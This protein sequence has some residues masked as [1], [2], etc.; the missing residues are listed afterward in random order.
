MLI[1]AFD[2]ATDMCTVAL[3]KDEVL[4]KEI[5]LHAERTHMGKLIPLID[6]L[7]GETNFKIKNVDGI[8]VGLGPGSFTGMRIG[9]STARGL[10]Q[11]L[12]KPVVGVSTLDCLAYPFINS[13]SL[14]LTV[15]DAKRKEIYATLYEASEGKLN[16]LTNY[17]VMAPESLVEN[18]K[19]EKRG[20]IMVGDGLKVYGELFKQSLKGALFVEEAFWYPRAANL[21]VPGRLKF[22]FESGDFNE[23][24]PIYARLSQAEEIWLNKKGK[25]G[26]G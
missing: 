8:I 6:S 3:E 22:S 17:Q 7:L 19:N 1:L 5:N 24:K 16:R 25:I 10:S 4:L 15:L 12:K 20:L 2:T 14:I 21:F 13:N 9:V 11:A 18:L 23:L 26:E